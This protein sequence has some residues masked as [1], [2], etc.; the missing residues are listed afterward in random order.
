[1]RFSKWHAL[2]NSYL[3]IERAEAGRPLDAELV[4]RLCDVRVGIGSDGVLE[5]L[6]ADGP[7]ADVTIWNPDG[8]TAEFSGNGSRIAALWLAGRS[9]ASEVSVSVAVSG[10]SYDA[11]LRGDGLVAMTIGHVEV[12]EFEAIVLPRRTGPGRGGAATASPWRS[13]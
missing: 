11:V 9:G 7:T 3:L 4:R 10:R 1:M 13:T 5:I 6:A 2:G 8:T 12:G